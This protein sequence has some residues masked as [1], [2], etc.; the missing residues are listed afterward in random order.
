M[1]HQMIT[2][3]HVGA[4]SLGFA[5]TRL[6]RLQETIDRAV[7]WR[8]DNTKVSPGFL[9]ETLADAIMMGQ[10]PLIQVEAF[11]NKQDWEQLFRGTGITPEQLNDDAYGRVLD[12]LASV[13][14]D[15][16]CMEISYQ[17]LMQQG[18][19]IQT[20]H[21]G[22]TSLSVQGA[23]NNQDDYGHGRKTSYR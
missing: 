13:D 9:V 4:V 5:L 2:P 23:F 15:Q 12:K 3:I 7:N 21:A 18:C 17:L 11:W 16:L 1:N 8:P 6:S 19:E 14:M 20:I 10:I 22:T